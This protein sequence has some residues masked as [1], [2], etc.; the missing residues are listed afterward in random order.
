MKK[1]KVVLISIFSVGIIGAASAQADQDRYDGDT[2]KKSEYKYKDEG[3]DAN[4]EQNTYFDT[5]TSAKN[6]KNM[7]NDKMRNQNNETIYQED[8]LNE[9]PGG[10]SGEYDYDDPNAKDRMHKNKPNDTHHNKSNDENTN[11]FGSPY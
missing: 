4:R 5:T 6:Q 11:S 10:R 9:R 3:G 7:N 2:R 8:Q 1:I